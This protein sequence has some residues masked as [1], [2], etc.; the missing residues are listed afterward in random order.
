LIKK[1]QG[2]SVAAVR[3]SQSLPLKNELRVGF[4]IKRKQDIHFF[5]LIQWGKKNRA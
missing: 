5:E 2:L 1:T 3:L 4:A